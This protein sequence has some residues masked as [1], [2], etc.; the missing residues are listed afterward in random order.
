MNTLLVTVPTEVIYQRNGSRLGHI[1][2]DIITQ[3]LLKEHTTRGFKKYWGKDEYTKFLLMQAV[4]A[5]LSDYY[6]Y[7]MPIAWTGPEDQF[8]LTKLSFPYDIHVCSDAEQKIIKDALIYHNASK[9]VRSY[10]WYRRRK[11]DFPPTIV[12]Q[13]IMEIKL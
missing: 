4:T 6:H 9:P 8:L 11:L 10:L 13:M 3:T 7:T 5:G 12:N 1:R 2:A